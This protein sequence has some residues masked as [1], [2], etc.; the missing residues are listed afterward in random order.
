[1]SVGSSF[2]YLGFDDSAELTTGNTYAALDTLG[3]INNVRILDF[4][5]DCADG[6]FSGAERTTLTE[7]GNDL[8]L[9]EVLTSVRGQVLSTT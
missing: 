6:T 5:G 7:I 1:M 2:D 9:H 3:G 4:T 8:V